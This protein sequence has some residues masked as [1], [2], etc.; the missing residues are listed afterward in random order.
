LGTD[1]PVSNNSLDMFETM[2][3]CALLHKADRWDARVFDA[4]KVFDLATIEGA[5]AIG[6]EDAIGSIEVGKR[7]DLAVLDFSTPRTTP[8]DRSRIVSH[9]VYSCSGA[10]VTTTIVDGRIVVAD[11]KAQHLKEDVIY[12]RANEIAVEL[13]EDE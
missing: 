4:Q 11:G 1:S 9:I 2:K 12:E 3:F 6:M 13:F 10:N 5:R 8:Y 7:A